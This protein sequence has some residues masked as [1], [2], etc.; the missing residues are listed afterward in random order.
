MFSLKYLENTQNQL[1]RVET[2]LKNL[3]LSSAFGLYLF[4]YLPSSKKNYDLPKPSNQ[5]TQP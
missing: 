2:T 1:N 3:K 5:D 4:Y